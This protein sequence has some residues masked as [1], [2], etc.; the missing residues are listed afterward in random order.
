[1]EPFPVGHDGRV[2]RVVGGDIGAGVGLDGRNQRRQPD[3]LGRLDDGPLL[4]EREQA[5][6]RRL[7]AAQRG[8][9]VRQKRLVAGLAGR[10]DVPARGH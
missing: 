1:M 9:G 5:V 2:R 7:H 10:L 8:L 3:R 6:H 4:G